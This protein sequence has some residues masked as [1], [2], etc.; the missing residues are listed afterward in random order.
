MRSV[1][2]FQGPKELEKLKKYAV[3]SLDN[4]EKLFVQKMDKKVKAYI[5]KESDD[6]LTF[7]EVVKLSTMWKKYQHLKPFGFLFNPEKTMPKVFQNRVAFIIWTVWGTFHLLGEE[8]LKGAAI[9]AA[10]ILSKSHPPYLPKVKE[11]AVRRFAVFMENTGYSCSDDLTISFWE[12]KIFP[13]LE[14]VWEFKWELNS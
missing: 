13:Y 4:E 14:G 1:S 12:E 5:N 11:E 8:D 3:D 7:D 9:A 6:F 10:N 2:Y